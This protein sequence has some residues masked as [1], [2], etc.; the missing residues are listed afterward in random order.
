VQSTVQLLAALQSTLTSDDDGTET[1][2]SI[3]RRPKIPAESDRD[4]APRLG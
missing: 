4:R 1:D 3:G 2:A